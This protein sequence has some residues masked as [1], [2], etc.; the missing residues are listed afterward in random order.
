MIALHLLAMLFSFGRL[1][2]LFGI[3]KI[4]EPLRKR[5]PSYLWS[6]PRCLSIWAGIAVV[7]IYLTF[8]WLNWPL[9]LS[10]LFIARLDKKMASGRELRI[11]VKDG[12]ANWKN[13]LTA[14]EIT[15][16]MN[17]ILRPKA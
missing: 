6:C 2:E 1:I 15:S 12:R 5:F 3:D 8:P 7:L 9:A 11:V 10:W 4:T 16:A 14:E 17:F 13:D